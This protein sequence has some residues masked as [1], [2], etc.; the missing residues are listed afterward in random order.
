MSDRIHNM[1]VQFSVLQRNLPLQDFLKKPNPLD[2]NFS[3][4]KYFKDIC[5]PLKNKEHVWTIRWYYYVLISVRHIANTLVL[6]PNLD[7]Y[8]SFFCWQILPH[9]KINIL[10]GSSKILYRKNVS[11]VLWVT[12]PYLVGGCWGMH[13]R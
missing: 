8:L 6:L 2:I 5:C 1:N 3:I 12:P 13:N 10:V 7:T 9:E 4:L 11:D